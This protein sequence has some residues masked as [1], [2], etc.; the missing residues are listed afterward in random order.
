[1]ELRS[2]LKWPWSSRL[3]TQDIK[4]KVFF[5]LFILINGSYYNRDRTEP[6][7]IHLYTCQNFISKSITTCRNGGFSLYQLGEP[8]RAVVANNFQTLVDYFSLTLQVHCRF[9]RSS[10]PCLLIW[11]LMLSEQPPSQ[12]LL[13]L[14]WRERV[15]E[16]L[17]VKCSVWTATLLTSTHS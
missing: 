5:S 7:F 3:A 17:T 10:V 15:S 1:M 9:A 14:W 2:H 6:V 11:G 8:A 16:E 13:S 12:M 4:P